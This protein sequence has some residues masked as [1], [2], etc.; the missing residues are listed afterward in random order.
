MKKEPRSSIKA[1]APKPSGLFSR[2]GCTSCGA[3]PITARAAVLFT[4]TPREALCGISALE[5][6]MYNLSAV[7]ATD[8]QAIRI[9]GAVFRDALQREPAFAYEAL[10]LCTRRLQ[11]IALQYGAIAEPVSHRVIRAI[12][13]LQDQF[14]R[15]L[16]VTHRELAQMAWTTTESAIRVVRRLKQQGYVT[17]T[18]N[19]LQLSHPEKLARELKV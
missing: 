2:G 7:A 14:G 1:N 4:I 6:G 15:T 13:R 3:R 16:P 10:R 9:S 17:G 18:R 12:L 19:R 5:S 8:C 11:N